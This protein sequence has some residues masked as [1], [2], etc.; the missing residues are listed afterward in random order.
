MVRHIIMWRLK[1][2][3]PESKGR[4]KEV[5]LGMQGKIPGMRS[6]E[7]GL[8][9]NATE[10]AFDVVLNTVHDTPADLELYQAHPE[11][12]KVK[13]YTSQASTAKTVVDF[14]M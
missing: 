8:N 6:I 2:R 12:L 5:L 14:E 3:T 4:M 9:I 10:A 7:V 11:H 13:A 1:D